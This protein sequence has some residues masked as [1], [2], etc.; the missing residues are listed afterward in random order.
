[1]FEVGL[2]RAVAVL[3]EKRAGGAA[4]AAR[5]G[6]RRWRS[7]APTRPTASRC[8]CSPAATAPTSSTA[9][10]TPTCPRGADPPTLTLDEAVEL[11]AEREAKGPSKGKRGAGCDEGGGAG[12]GEEAGREEEAREGAQGEVGARPSG[13]RARAELGGSGAADLGSVHLAQR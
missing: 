13:S 10:P 12:Q 7:W 2:N 9:R 11:L 3:A 6:A 5:G 8:A 4:A 1:M